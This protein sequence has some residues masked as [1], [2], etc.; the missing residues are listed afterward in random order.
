MADKSQGTRSEKGLCVG[1]AV[2]GRRVMSGM[3]PDVL[4]YSQLLGAIWPA[5]PRVEKLNRGWNLFIAPPPRCLFREGKRVPW[6]RAG[7]G[8]PLSIKCTVFGS[9]RRHVSRV[10]TASRRPLAVICVFGSREPSRMATLLLRAG[11]VN[12]SGPGR[13]V[14]FSG[15][16]CCCQSP[17][18][19]SSH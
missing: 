18:R 1:L 15:F 2:A 17:L 7:G 19:V 13:C 16:G 6:W 9:S 4:T 10:Y 12:S 11:S 8:C 5:R 3:S 14:A